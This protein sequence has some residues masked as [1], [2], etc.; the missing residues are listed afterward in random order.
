MIVPSTENKDRIIIVNGNQTWEV[1]LSGNQVDPCVPVLLS[2]LSMRCHCLLLQSSLLSSWKAAF[3]ITYLGCCVTTRSIIWKRWLKSQQN[4]C[5]CHI[6]MYSKN[7]SETSDRSSINYLCQKYRMDHVEEKDSTGDFVSQWV[8]SVWWYWLVYSMCHQ[9]VW[10][11]VSGH[12][13]TF[14]QVTTTVNSLAPGRFKSKYRYVIF[15]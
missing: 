5:K 8:C 13:T 1:F 7:I 12:H 11:C 2:C 15:M 6:Q 9:I 10:C 14:Q 3:L 4:L